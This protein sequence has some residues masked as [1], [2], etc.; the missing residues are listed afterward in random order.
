[1]QM[2]SE[3]EGSYTRR[4]LYTQKSEQEAEVTLDTCRRYR[5]VPQM[6]QTEKFKQSH[7]EV[8]QTKTVRAAHSTR[9]LQETWCSPLLRWYLHWWKGRVRPPRPFLRGLSA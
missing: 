9:G 8:I 7:Q 3:E 4:G 6:P 5:I 1:M 2:K